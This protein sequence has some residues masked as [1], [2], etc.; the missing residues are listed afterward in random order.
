MNERRDV[1][2]V[3]VHCIDGVEMGGFLS[4]ELEA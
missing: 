4:I 3:Y 1:S 2:G